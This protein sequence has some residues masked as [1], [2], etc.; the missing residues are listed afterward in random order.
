MYAGIDMDIW[1][2]FWH[3][4]IPVY[5]IQEISWIEDCDWI[6]ITPRFTGHMHC[7]HCSFGHDEDK[8]STKRNSQ[9][10]FVI[11]RAKTNN[12]FSFSFR[13]F[14]YS[15]T[16]WSENSYLIFCWKCIISVW[17]VERFNFI[18]SERFRIKILSFY[19]ICI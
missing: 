18:D 13:F 5:C 10:V 16:W 9:Q 1:R 19:Q 8:N 3:N 7:H 17:K 12:Q 14:M 4:N 2:R 15:F 6:R 11:G